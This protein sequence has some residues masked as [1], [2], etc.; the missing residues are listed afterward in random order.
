[1]RTTRRRPPNPLPTS[2]WISASSRRYRWTSK[3]WSTSTLV[4][5]H[6]DVHR[7]RLELA[8]IHVEVGNGFGGRRRVVLIGDALLRFCQ[9]EVSEEQRLRGP[10]HLGEDR[11]VVGPTRHRLDGW[12]PIHG[13]SSRGL[14]DD[15]V[16]EQRWGQ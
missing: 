14:A 2:T 11:H 12:L 16:H 10:D 5:Q 7:Y 8:E 3:C 9:H 4:D 15:G 6:F 13:C 1:M